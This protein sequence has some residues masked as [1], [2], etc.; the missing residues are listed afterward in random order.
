M[1]QAPQPSPPI[2]QDDSFDLLEFWI[3]HKSS[4]RAVTILFSAAL[5]GY[6][7]F[8]WIEKQQEAAAAE[9]FASAKSAEE[10]NAFIASHKGSTLGGN[11]ALLL[12]G[13]RTK[14]LN[15][16]V[17]WCPWTLAALQLPQRISGSQGFS[18][19]RTSWT[20]QRPL[21]KHCNHSSRAPPSPTRHY[22]K[23]R[24]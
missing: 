9:A 10:L 15:T 18:K 12:A 22:L 11:A 5:V 4:I 2:H 24:R 3:R 6:G 17:A 23:V 1:S 21:T 13:K 19:A 8:S 16:I 7:A 14:L 20:K